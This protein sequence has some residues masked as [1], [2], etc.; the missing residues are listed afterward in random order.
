MVKRFDCRAV[1]DANGTPA[2]RPVNRR[3][4]R[5]RLRKVPSLLSVHG[6]LQHGIA[7]AAGRQRGLFHHGVRRSGRPGGRAVLAQARLAPQLAEM[8]GQPGERGAPVVDLLS[9]PLRLLANAVWGA[10]E[11]LLFVKPTGSSG[12]R[13]THA[14]PEVP[15]QGH[16]A[17]MSNLHCRIRDRSLQRRRRRRYGPRFGQLAL[18][19][20]PGLA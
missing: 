6:G 13:V 1:G 8:P 16:R 15:R 10:W 17:G 7:R 4:V 12:H 20:A 5:L 11:S 14:A 9:A 3:R 18:S 2:R 19:C